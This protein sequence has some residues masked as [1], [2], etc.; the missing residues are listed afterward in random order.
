MNVT[1]PKKSWREIL[2]TIVLAGAAIVL[3]LLSAHYFFR[4]AG[5][6]PYFAADD[7]LYNISF[8]FANRGVFGF[9][10]SPVQPGELLS[11]RDDSFY[12]HGPWAYYIVAFFDWVFGPSIMVSRLAHPAML[13]LTCV[14]AHLTLRRYAQSASLL[15]AGI[16]FFVFWYSHWPMM[17]PDPVVAAFA[18]A[19]LYS[20]T[21]AIETNQWW[22]WFLG[23]FA[24]ASTAATHQIA[25]AI[26][27]FLV[28]TWL[29]ISARGQPNK[30]RV[31]GLA[32]CTGF[33]LAFVLYLV[34][35]DFRIFEV[36]NLLLF[37]RDSVGDGETTS[38][39]AQLML[40]GEAYW[41]PLHP[42]IK[43]IFI[44]GLLVAITW[45]V[46]ARWVIAEK[47][48]KPSRLLLPPIAMLIT[49]SASLGLYP[50]VHAGYGIL[51]HVLLAW[52]S[53]GVFALFPSLIFPDRGF[54]QDAL[55][56]AR[57]AASIIGIA[58]V[59]FFF[60]VR[61][62]YLIS[63]SQTF[64]P[65]EDLLKEVSSYVGQNASAWGTLQFG[66]YS[67]G[68]YDLIQYGDGA[69]LSKTF[70]GIAKQ[71]IAPDY[72]V[73]AKETQF[74]FSGDLILNKKSTYAPSNIV[75]GVSYH[76]HAI[77]YAE[78]YGDIRIYKRVPA[79][80]KPAGPP[81][82]SVNF[83]GTNHWAKKPMDPI[84][85]DF[86]AGT[87]SELTYSIFKETTK[88]TAQASETLVSEAP[89]YAGFYLFE[90]SVCTSMDQE[91]GVISISNRKHDVLTQ[92]PTAD[93]FTLSPYFVYEDKI[94]AIY[95][96]RGGKVRVNRF[97]NTPCDSFSVS[98]IAPVEFEIPFEQ[99]P[100]QF[101]AFEGWPV[102]SPNGTMVAGHDSNVRVTG[103]ASTGSYQFA[104]PLIDVPP[105]TRIEL[106]V[107]I[108]SVNGSFKVGIL[109]K[110]GGGWLAAPQP[111]GE[112]F[113]FFSGAN[114]SIEI[115]VINN[116]PT[117]LDTPSV[118]DIRSGKITAYR[119]GPYVETLSH[120]I[121]QRRGD[122]QDQSLRPNFMNEALPKA[123]CR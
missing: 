122:S 103:D 1:D 48:L 8:S 42:L 62:P 57:D 46:I 27:L 99:H 93:D 37:Y 44:T 39:F 10:A 5:I 97:A 94:W 69:R 71:H 84:D 11:L 81:L 55:A 21:R 61:P 30:W 76:L 110:W 50:N 36:L 75:P 52:I 107:P 14:A 9:P 15:F 72:L 28:A 96:H 78:P 70:N 49:Y 31:S 98:S 26:P 120:C 41:S 90:L 123:P 67:G 100:I 109:D 82:I 47:T 2:T 51:V 19:T 74:I 17:R 54:K 18:A 73:L 65:F 16:L 58:A 53:C 33:T 108:L 12:N 6:L 38:Y 45:I 87:S 59:I 118:F 56:T 22:H 35:I 86:I 104:S 20:T 95:K 117:A 112:P 23:A 77:V 66:I 92:T 32:V 83:K 29:L 80:A 88:Y 13:C 105:Y 34:A 4:S 85:V 25:F 115:V 63:K 89:L 106:T 121:K 68:H 114:K 113:S 111:A 7:S 79:A 102:L 60:I 40:H 3:L 101:P 116:N 43:L 91:P 24:A 119:R 64:I